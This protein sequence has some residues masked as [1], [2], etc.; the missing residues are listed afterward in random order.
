MQLTLSTGSNIQILGA[1][2]FSFQI[3]ANAPAGDSS[4]LL[5]YSQFGTALGVTIP[6]GAGSASGTPN[7]TVPTGMGSELLELPVQ[8][9]LVG[10]GESNITSHASGLAF[11]EP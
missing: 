10:V 8:A 11:S 4:S 2:K 1:S 5:S 7:F 3:G 6:A 9:S